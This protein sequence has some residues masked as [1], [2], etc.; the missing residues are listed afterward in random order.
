MRRYIVLDADDLEML[1]DNKPI[2]M[3][4]DGTKFIVC[5]RSYFDDNYR[6]GFRDANSLSNDVIHDYAGKI[7]KLKEK[8]AEQEERGGSNG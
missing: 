4:I 5:S 8:L 7:R 1:F 2:E 6:K 3:T